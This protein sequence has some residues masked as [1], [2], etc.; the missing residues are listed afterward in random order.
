AATQAVEYDPARDAEPGKILHELRGG[1]MA[2]LGEVPFGAYY[3]SVAA[4]QVFILLAGRYYDRTGYLATIKEL[5]PHIEAALTWIDGD[6]DRD[7]D[8]F[9]DDAR[10]TGRALAQ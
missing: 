6:G 5:W 10:A 2:A 1:E 9:G 8:G 4:K 3:G 7:G